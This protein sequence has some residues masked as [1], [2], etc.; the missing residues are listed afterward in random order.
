[1][2]DISI[3]DT[4]LY[5]EDLSET[6]KK[7]LDSIK[8]K[9]NILVQ[10]IDDEQPIISQRYKKNICIP[11]LPYLQS[12]QYATLYQYISH[13]CVFNDFIN[14]FYDNQAIPFH[15]LSYP[16]LKSDKFL[17]VKWIH[18]HKY[19]L[20]SFLDFKDDEIVIQDLIYTFYESVKNIDDILLILC[21]K[22]DDRNS[23]SSM[24]E[25]I[26]RSLNINKSKSQ[27]LL[28]IQNHFTKSDTAAIINTADC[29]ILCNAI[30]LSDFEYYYGISQNKKIIS[31]YN[32]NSNYNINLIGSH[33]KMINY[34]GS[35]NFYD[36][37]NNDD[38][39]YALNNRQHFNYNFQ[40][41]D[42]TNIIDII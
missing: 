10:I 18:K 41:S 4:N 34:K 25:Q 29:L 8:P 6:I 21:I 36:H 2:S 39:Y 14:N 42:T 7:E 15:Q 5:K 11:K 30:Y 24:F 31:K 1:M 40:N 35:R 22:S 19:K 32:L 33:K 28:L 27:I 9:D 12:K 20:V 3:I 17:T 13:V 38:M 37:F 23:V 16:V 26:H